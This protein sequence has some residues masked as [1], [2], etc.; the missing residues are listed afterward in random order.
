MTAIDL[1]YLCRILPEPLLVA[2]PIGEIYAA[3]DA[4]AD[5]LKRAP[6]DLGGKGL[7]E[8]VADSTETVDGLLTLFGRSRQFVPGS[9]SFRNGASG[10][11]DCRVEGALVN[12]P[13]PALLIRL[14]PKDDE[15]SRFGALNSRTSP[16]DRQVLDGGRASETASILSTIVD[17]CND[18]IVSKDLDGVIK[19]WNNA[20]ERI[21]GYTAKEAVGQSITILIPPDRLDEEPQILEK[22]RRGEMVDHFETVRVRKD[23]T[24]LNISV[25]ISPIR[26]EEGQIVGASKVARDITERKKISALR[27]RLAAIVESSDDAITSTGLDGTILSWNVGAER[28]FG[29]SASEVLGRHVSVL[30]PNDCVDEIPAI[31]NR[32]SNGE[33]IDH[34]ETKRLRKNGTILTISLTIFPI[35]NSQG[36]I[37]GA[38]TVARDITTQRTLSELHG[39]MAA[40]VESSD[41]A[42]VSKDLTGTINSW[43]RG[44]ERIFGYKAAEV[45]GKP[46]TIII[47]DDRFDEEPEILR[48]LQRGEHVDHFE[49]V[50]RR[51]DGSLVPVSLTISPV[52]DATG[53]VIGASKIAR[54][55]TERDHHERELR[56]ANAAL[57]RANADL[58][59]FAYS[60]SHDLQE[61]LRMVATYSE[62]LKRE[63]GGKLGPDGEEYLRYTVQGAVRMEHLL[64]D[65]RMFTLVS[66]FGKEPA[67]DFETSR[68]F[69]LALENLKDAID[70]SGAVLT[71]TPLP[72]IRVHQ[73]QMEQL[74]QNLIGNAIR[75][76][77]KRPPRVHVAAQESGVDW[78]F[79]VQDNGIG[80]DPQYK[81]QIFGMFKRLHNTAEYPGTGMGL[82]ICQRIVERIGGRIWV[83][84][85]LGR[86]ATFFFTIPDR[87]R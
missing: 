31:L 72:C 49:T 5:L 14:Q 78:V 33:T 80:I 21:F 57:T 53:K 23:G 46:I 69:D 68:A 19:T 63:F 7:D 54:D 24:H 84:S 71:R 17:T 29:Y 30:T 42:I 39:R 87:S 67:E 34:Y 74:F 70:A 11:I 40:I 75:Y 83:E 55:I 35:S 32:V 41:D 6:A 58:Q 1:Q 12:A 77:S 37:I 81:E 50:R 43:N 25:T 56:E 73:F 13:D 28:L 4:A 27:E 15:N 9:L 45:I 18:A 16:P 48:R 85:E 66:S 38:S 82:A 3:N 59:L 86:G 10:N 61:P 20:A 79:S 65:L 26:N 8:L 62:L 36:I 22:L 52:K 47:P 44:A 2:S 60:A 76:K 64:K 51:K